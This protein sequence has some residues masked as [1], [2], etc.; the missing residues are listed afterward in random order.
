MNKTCNKCGILKDLTKFRL[1]DKNG[2]DRRKGVCNTCCRNAKHLNRKSDP[3]RWEE[4][5]RKA[6]ERNKK[7]RSSPG[8]KEKEMVR[9]SKYK[10]AARQ[11]REAKRDAKIDVGS[12]C[13]IYTFNCRRCSSLQLR[14]VGLL[15]SERHGFLC[16]GCVKTTFMFKRESIC[17]N[18]GCSMIAG[19]NRVNCDTCVK[20]KANKT[21][22]DNGS[23]RITS[24]ARKHGVIIEPVSRKRVYRRDDYKCYMCGVDVVESKIYQPNQATLDHVIPLSKGGSHIYD[25]IKTCCHQCNSMKSDSISDVAGEGFSTPGGHNLRQVA[26]QHPLAPCAHSP[27]I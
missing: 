20:A 2:G 13:D 22:R 4:H 5:L 26:D 24:R 8:F 15:K 27:S 6:M 19:P 21:R 25:N 11:K 7:Q 16:N 9:R 18:C 3:I 1:K 23:R 17:K 10:V 12:R 14:G